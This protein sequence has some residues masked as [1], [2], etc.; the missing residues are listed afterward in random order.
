MNPSSVLSKKHHAA[1]FHLLRVEHSITKNVEHHVR[2]AHTC[3]VMRVSEEPSISSQKHPRNSASVLLKK[4]HAV[5]FPLL[6]VEF[7]V[8]K[9]VMVH[10]STDEPSFSS[11]KNTEGTQC[12]FFK[13]YPVVMF[14]LLRM[15]EHF[16][17]KILTHMSVDEPSIS[18][19]EK[20][21]RNSAS[22]FSKKHPFTRFS[23][24]RVEHS[25]H[26]K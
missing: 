3:H 7:S 22:V 11:L 1:L 17:L 21:L 20:H 18:C 25:V 13:K 19:F 10:A 26:K 2:T 9:N 16:A 4:H 23:L 24:L 15:M 6:Q 5:L 12:Q 8:L 14:P